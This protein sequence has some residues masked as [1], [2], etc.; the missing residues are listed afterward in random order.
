MNELVNFSNLSHVDQSPGHCLA[1]QE[2]LCH[3]QT[4]HAQSPSQPMLL[5]KR[6]KRKRANGLRPAPLPLC[7]RPW[8][9][10][11]LSKGPDLESKIKEKSP[12][13]K[14]ETNSVLGK[15]R[16]QEHKPLGKGREPG[17]GGEGG[18]C[19]GCW[20]CSVPVLLYSMLAG[21]CQV[22]LAVQWAGFTGF[23][24]PSQVSWAPLW[25][26]PLSPGH[27]AAAHLP[28]ELNDPNRPR[29]AR[30]QTDGSQA[31]HG[32]CPEPRQTPDKGG[33]ANC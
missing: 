16:L 3:Q 4:Y 7:E 6:A 10:A 23:Q 20:A 33:P 29:G 28:G 18:R 17:P 12:F 2:S 25:G 11:I 13:I 31:W 5:R 15:L 24:G 22:G 8:P 14:T 19:Q 9:S 32:I 1:I 21:E 30:P 26:L 27:K